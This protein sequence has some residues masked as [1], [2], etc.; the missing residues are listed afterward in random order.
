MPALPASEPA[1]VVFDTVILL[2]GPVEESALAGVLCNHNPRL[3]IHTAKSLPELEAIDISILRRAR[4]IAFVTPV[5]VP[6]R[7]LDALGFGGYNFHPGPP[8]Y[9]GWVPCH[10]AI[11]ERAATFGATAHIMIEKV[12]AGPIVG[13]EL[14]PVP[15]NTSPSGLEAIAFSQLARLFWRMAKTL[16]MQSEPVPELPIQWSGRRSTRRHYAAMCDIPTTI[17]KEELDRR[18]EVFG[19]GHFGV[20]PTVTIHGY[21]FRYAAPAKNG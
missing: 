2:T 11:Y 1:S 19:A 5:V 7:I 6:A 15:P 4:L 20:S 3:S 9:P 16:A 14:F 17:S 18:I 12:D 21:Q 8:Q 10:F 13:L